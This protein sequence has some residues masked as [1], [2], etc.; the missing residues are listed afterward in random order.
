M[1]GLCCPGLFLFHGTSGYQRLNIVANSLLSVLA[2][3]WSS[4]WAPSVPSDNF[5]IDG[6]CM[7]GPTHLPLRVYY[8][9]I[10]YSKRYSC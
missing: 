7:H 3:V 8:Y 1:W 9:I 2:R 5:W 6:G 4:K 10:C